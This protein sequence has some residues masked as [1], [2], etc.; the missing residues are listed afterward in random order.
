MP[1]A[2]IDRIDLKILIELQKRGR[3]TNAELADAVGLSASPCLLRVKRLQ[4]AGIIAGYGAAIDLRKL[5][6]AIHVFLEVTLT[7]HRTESF[8]VFENGLRRMPEVVEAHL[9][10][11]GFDY[12]VRIVVRNL[13][14]FQEVVETMLDGGLGVAKYVSYIVVKSPID[15]RVYPLK[16]LLEGEE[17]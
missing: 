10:S 17:D 3:I 15:S 14:H 13:T 16:L 6:E 9:I 11:G 7:Q 2:K 5:G 12:L 1:A 8:A 4:K